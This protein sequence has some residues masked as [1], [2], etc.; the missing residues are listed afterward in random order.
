MD[1]GSVDGR[2]LFVTFG[3]F[4]IVHPIPKMPA[5]KG[6]KNAKKKRGGEGRVLRT[7]SFRACYLW[8]RLSPHTMGQQRKA[9]KVFALS[10]P[11]GKRLGND[12]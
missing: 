8:L 10:K 1:G 4:V 6:R 9:G 12:S 3:T 5:K 2:L 11:S 7:R